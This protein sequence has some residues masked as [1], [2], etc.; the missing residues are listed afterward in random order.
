MNRVVASRPSQLRQLIEGDDVAFLMEAHNGLS[1][2]IVEEAGFAGIWASGLSIAASLGVRDANEASW[3]QVL[4]VVEFM[5]DATKLPIL[6][7]GDTGYGDFNSARRLVKKL[8]AR[9]IAGVCLEDKI[10]PKQNSFIN[11]NKQALA[12]IEEFAGKITAARDASGDDDFC[13]VARVEAF[14]AGWG[15]AEALKRAHAYADAGAHAILIHSARRD[16]DEILAFKRAFGAR[17]PVVVVPTKYYTTPTSVLKDAGF[18][19][20]IWANHLMRSALTA[21]QTT[22]KQIFDDQHLLNVEGS[23]G[24]VAPLAEVFRLQGQDELEAAEQRYL[25]ATT[26]KASAVVLAAARGKEL[27]ALT[28]DKPKCML[29]LAGTP[30]LARITATLQAAG[31]RDV[32]VVR[33]YKK[34]AVVVAGVTTMF[35]ND[36][37]ERTA[38]VGSLLCARPA[39]EKPAGSSV[40]VSYGDV[41]FQPHVIDSLCACDD[42]IVIAVDPDWRQSRNRNGRHADLVRCSRPATRDAFLHTTTLLEVPNTSVEG[43]SVVDGGVHG[44][45]IG[46]LKLSATG[47]Q[48][49]LAVLDAAAAAGTDV[50]QWRMPDVLRAALLGDQR[51]R[52]LYTTGT[53]LDVDTVEDLGEAAP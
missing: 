42:D 30:I 29:P 20:I 11:G 8:H 19:T 53:W 17:L 26:T 35:D 3:T 15:L 48:R 2:K 1:A 27:G 38:E 52:V 40:V 28:D 25:P 46:V 14:I 24:R 9:G 18:S 31:I 16:A 32:A 21:M 51:V 7:D 12:G 36:A 45:W 43:A 50:T 13:V 34:E 5:A 49:V 4:E 47:A 23:L 33:G 44:E 22:A 41:V 39:L 10:F 37:H 6:V